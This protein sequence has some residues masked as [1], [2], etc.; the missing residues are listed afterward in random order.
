MIKF[1]KAQLASSI[2]SLVD[3]FITVFLVEAVGFWYLAGSTTGTIIGGITNFSIGRQW[4]FKGGI[5]ERHI[6]LFRYAMVWTGYL[7]L[8]TFGIY[9]LTHFG[10][11]NYLISKVIVS[12]FLAVA[13]NFPLQKRF[14]FR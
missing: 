3:Y 8:T 1:A 11:F 9:L 12:L 7:V 13:Y 5:K 4:V 6:Q 14:V 10:H 2:A